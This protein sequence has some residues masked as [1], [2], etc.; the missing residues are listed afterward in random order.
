MIFF[1]VLRFFN[2]G[3][4]AF[5]HLFHGLTGFSIFFHGV[6][7]FPLRVTTMTERRY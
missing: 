2:F 7:V 6:T 5:S 1:T 4:D 3:G